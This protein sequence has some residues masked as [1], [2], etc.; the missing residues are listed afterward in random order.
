MNH[1]SLPMP[2]FS[3]SE[4]KEFSAQCQR[5]RFIS[6]R[7]IA[8]AK[9]RVVKRTAFH[10]LP[11]MLLS[12]EVDADGRRPFGKE[13]LVAKIYGIQQGIAVLSLDDRI[14]Y[15]AHLSGFLSACESTGNECISSIQTYFIPRVPGITDN[16][17]VSFSW[18]P[19]DATPVQLMIDGCGVSKTLYFS[20]ERAEK[21][22]AFLQY[23][24]GTPP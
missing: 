20:G 3:V 15:H 21:L 23:F 17:Q 8:E 18:C 4:I 7:F 2:L 6:S 1:V 11:N 14:P 13:I 9:H 12:D 16:C 5:G 19:A 24:L 22:K 10:N